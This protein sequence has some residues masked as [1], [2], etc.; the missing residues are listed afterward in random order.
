[1]AV[2][3]HFFSTRAPET[4]WG[5]NEAG[6]IARSL[7]T[8]HGFGSTFHDY[9]GLTAWLAPGYPALVAVVFTFFGIETHASAVVLMLL[10]AIFSSLTALLVCKLGSRIFD[11]TTGLIAGW[12]WAVCPAAA[13]FP[14]LIWDTCL[15]TLMLSWAVVTWI[16]A[17]S[18]KRW[19]WSGAVWGLAGLVNPSLL[20]PLPLLMASS[21]WREK[22]WKSCAR[23]SLSCGLLLLPWSV[24]NELVFHRFVP[25]RSNMW[26]EIYFGNVDFSLHPLGPSMEYQRLGE[27]AFVDRL[28][29]GTVEY[30][31]SS[32]LRFARVTIKRTVLF[33]IGPVTWL[34]LTIPLALGTLCGLGLA[35][36]NAGRRSLPLV[37]PLLSYPLVYFISYVYSRYRHPIEPFMYLLTVYVACE[38]MR[39]IRRSRVPVDGLV[40]H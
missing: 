40:S 12:A 14:F 17:D 7:V 26:A 33:W 19:V 31:R 28:Q 39:A 8:G 11:R 27:I 22:N 36:G 10:N 13:I 16:A 4:M 2:L 35:I 20:A 37:V 5:S 15:S 30:I 1:M 21:L 29:Q 23:I 9:A 32:P 25:I 24:R 6:L 18:T 3:F 38:G 34:P